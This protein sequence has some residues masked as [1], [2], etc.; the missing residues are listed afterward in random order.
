MASWLEMAQHKN[1]LLGEGKGVEA[2]VE[3]EGYSLFEA[4]LLGH[5]P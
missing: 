5:P 3:L 4:R 1:V 2:W